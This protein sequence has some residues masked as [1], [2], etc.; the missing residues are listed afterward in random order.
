MLVVLCSAARGQKAGAVGGGGGGGGGH[1]A[2]CNPWSAPAAF[3]VSAPAPTP[4]PTPAPA[5]APNLHRQ[6]PT[7]T[8]T[9]TG[10]GT[11]TDR[12]RSAAGLARFCLTITMDAQA[13]KRLI[14]VAA[15][16]R[17]TCALPVCILP[18]SLSPPV[19]PISASA[20]PR[21]PLYPC[22][23]RAGS[24]SLPLS[25]SG[26]GSSPCLLKWR[27]PVHCWGTAISCRLYRAVGGSEMMAPG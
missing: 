3:F 13:W 21:R 23:N 16:I 18:I 4:T 24:D 5:P 12:V 19:W 10:T 7:Q 1:D 6:V 26:I 14:I 20:Y 8:T 11:G 9:A 2:R 27:Q 17:S 25:S 15:A 22:H